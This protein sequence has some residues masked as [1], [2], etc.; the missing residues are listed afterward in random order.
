MTTPPV[1]FVRDPQGRPVAVPR[2]DAADRVAARLLAEFLTI[3]VGRTRHGIA[4]ILARLDAAEAGAPAYGGVGNALEV[5]ID[6]GGVTLADAWRAPPERARYTAADLR[7][8]LAGWRAFVE[9]CDE[10]D[11]PFGPRRSS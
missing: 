8:A 4:A 3:E 9:A 7:Q 10:Q 6:A 5:A 1:A 11:E 2:D